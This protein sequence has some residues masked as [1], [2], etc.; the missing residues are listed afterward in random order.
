M[1][2][3]RWLAMPW[4]CSALLCASASAFFTTRI[5][6]ASPRALAATCSRCAA[7]MSFI[8]DFTFAS[9]TMSV[10]STDDLVAEA[11]HVGVE[12]LLHGSG[13]AGLA[14]ENL[15]QR[16]AGHMAENDLLDIGL[17][18]LHR[19]GQLVEGIVHFRTDAVLPRN[20][21]GD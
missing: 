17:D 8:A 7:L 15:I 14:G 4:P 21:N 3:L 13:D 9:G 10:T 5:F 19:V 2:A 1:M 6:S 18:L 20:R 11:G 16:H 12:L